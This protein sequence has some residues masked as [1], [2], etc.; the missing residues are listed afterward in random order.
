[1]VGETEAVAGAATRAETLRTAAAKVERA[2]LFITILLV[3]ENVR[4]RVPAA[5]N[6][7]CR[8]SI[9]SDVPSCSIERGRLTDQS[10]GLVELLV[11]TELAKSKSDARRQIGQGSIWLNN[12]R[13]SDPERL[14][15]AEDL[16]T[17]DSLVLRSGKK[18]YA[19]ARFVG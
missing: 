18:R 19:L 10:L 7:L 3:G 12:R 1:L 15:T 11:L 5:M 9:F 8:I 13:V 2:S 4:E 14:V 6:P 17:G 16:V